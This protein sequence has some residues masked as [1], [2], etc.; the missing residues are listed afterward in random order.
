MPTIFTD[1]ATIARE[2]RD[3]FCRRAGTERYPNERAALDANCAEVP[4]AAGSVARVGCAHDGFIALMRWAGFDAT[5]LELS[6]WLVEYAKLAFGVPMLTGTIEKQN[7]N[8]PAVYPAFHSRASACV[9]V[10]RW[11]LHGT[12]KA[13]RL[14]DRSNPCFPLAA[15]TGKWC[16]IRIVSRA[17]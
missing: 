11:T 10:A 1:A 4:P 17:V 6:P 5:G 3:R 15:P 14:H 13:G 12:A 9:P 8:R 2:G 16:E 7:L